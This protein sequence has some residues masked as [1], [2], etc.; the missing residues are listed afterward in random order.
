MLSTDHGAYCT[1]NKVNANIRDCFTSNMK[2][3]N[4]FF[5][6]FL[7]CWLETLPSA[8]AA[9]LTPRP[10]ALHLSSNYMNC[11]RRVK[12]EDAPLFISPRRTK[13]FSTIKFNLRGLLWRNLLFKIA[14]KLLLQVYLS[15]L[16]K[17]FANRKCHLCHHLNI[18]LLSPTWYAKKNLVTHSG[19]RVQLY[20]PLLTNFYRE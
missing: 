3:V 1:I 16:P 14:S 15:L 8:A 6:M 19:R 10:F 7:V 2:K 20:Y 17:R 11:T 5:N 4:H 18:F 13:S 12:R 9:L